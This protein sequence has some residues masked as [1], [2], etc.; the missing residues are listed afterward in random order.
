MKRLFATLILT[1]LAGLSFAD[2]P[3]KETTRGAAPDMPM[4][5]GMMM[6]RANTHGWGMMSAQERK[7]H[8][9]KMRNVKNYDECMTMHTEHRKQMEDRAKQQGRTLPEPRANMCDMMKEHGAFKK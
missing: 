7:A 9:D 8:H 3:T 5:R 1:T 4:G 2:D 6:G